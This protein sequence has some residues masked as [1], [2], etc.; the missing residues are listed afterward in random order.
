MKHILIIFARDIFLELLL[1]IYINFFQRM[2][3]FFCDIYF[4]PSIVMQLFF[5]YEISVAVYAT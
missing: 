4:F 5:F 2:F 1:I 3:S